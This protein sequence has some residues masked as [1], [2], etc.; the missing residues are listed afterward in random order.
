LAAAAAAGFWL[1]LGSAR[2]GY[3]VLEDMHIKKT[4][5]DMLELPL[6]LRHGI[7]GRLQIQIPWSTLNKDPILVDVD[8]V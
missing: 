3:L 8:R 4:L 2:T 6:A 5:M 1:T 7:I